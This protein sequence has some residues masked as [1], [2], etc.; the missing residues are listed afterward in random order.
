MGDETPQTFT[1]PHRDRVKV[2]VIFYS[3]ADADPGTELA[4]NSGT[5]DVTVQATELMLSQDREYQATLTSD[6]VGG[7]Q[8]LPSRTWGEFEFADGSST[9]IV[10]AA[11]SA[12][13][14]DAG[15]TSYRIALS[16]PRESE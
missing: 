13:P 4:I 1:F 2:Q 6:Y 9:A 15:A 12:P 16:I 7:T 11:Q 8:T 3:S 5:R 10:T 14:A